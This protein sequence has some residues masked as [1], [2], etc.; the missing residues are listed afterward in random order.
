M[1]VEDDPTL[2]T[3]WKRFFSGLGISDCRICNNPTIAWQILSQTPCHLLISDVTLPELNG[4]DLAKKARAQYP[5]IEILLTTAHVGDLSRF[6]LKGC[7]FHLLHKP[8]SNLDEL[9]SLIRCMLSGEDIYSEVS[10]DSFSDNEDYPQV[11]EW[12]L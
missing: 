2:M 12:K 5:S 9:T 10:E 7:Q 3:F 6:D 8:F 11:T 4:F 1:I